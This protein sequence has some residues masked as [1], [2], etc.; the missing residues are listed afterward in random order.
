MA[1][2]LSHISMIEYEEHL[3]PYAEPKI[4]LFNNTKLTPDEAFS[5]VRAGEYDDN[6][7]VLYKSQWMALFKN[8]MECEN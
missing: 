3:G 8:E 2:L 6:I 7:L 1:N 5:K 4:A